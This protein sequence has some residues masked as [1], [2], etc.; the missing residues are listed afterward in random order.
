[1][2]QIQTFEK[3]VAGYQALQAT[4]EQKIAQQQASKAL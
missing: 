1:M 4:Y 3:I 2:W